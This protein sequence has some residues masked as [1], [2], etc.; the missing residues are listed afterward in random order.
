MNKKTK[1]QETIT[2]KKDGRGGARPGA[3]RKPLFGKKYNFRAPK[4]M[5]DIIDRQPNKAAF[6]KG[7]ISATLQQETLTAKLVD[8]ATPIDN[9]VLVDL[10]FV[11][12]AVRAGFP[13]MMDNN[14]WPDVQKVPRWM[15]RHPESSVMMRVKGDSMIGAGILDGD[16]VVID[17]SLCNP[18]AD[19]VAFCE[20]EGGYTIKYF[21]MDADSKRA[22]LVP[23]NDS[24][25]KMEVT[26]DKSFHIWGTVTAHTHID[27]R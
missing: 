25:P 1:K 26:E 17:K 10:P 27:I 4:E 3:G 14:V 5:A 6:I 16:Y 24:Y 23:A 2:P 7:C 11:D 20:Y 19:E 22:W 15:C 21:R 18:S 12:E 13:V 9:M 8:N